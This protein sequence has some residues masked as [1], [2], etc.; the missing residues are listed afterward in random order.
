MHRLI[1]LRL[2]IGRVGDKR[3]EGCLGRKRDERLV[4]DV[5]VGIERRKQARSDSLDIAFRA[6]DLP[7]K[8]DLRARDA[9]GTVEDLRRVD[10]RISVHDAVAEE[11]CLLKSWNQAEHPLLLGPGKVRL[12]AHQIVG[13]ASL[14]LG[15]QLHGRPGTSAGTWI[16]EA[17]WLQ[18][19]EAQGID[20]CA[21]HFL[22][23]LAGAEEI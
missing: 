1:V 21:C 4:R 9:E 22:D 7:G 14:V 8:A 20:T 19:T 5:C 3:T 6:A 12:E 18:G 17:D 23:R 16:L 10:E 2:R 11:L 13:S 15:S